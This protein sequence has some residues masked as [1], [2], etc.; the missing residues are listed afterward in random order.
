MEINEMIYAGVNIP[1][2][3]YEGPF[4]INRPAVCNGG[5][6]SF[7]IRDIE[8][9]A[10]NVDSNGV[11]LQNISVFAASADS[12]ALLIRDDTLLEDISVYGTVIGKAAEEGFFNIPYSLSVGAV[13]PDTP[14]EFSIKI[15]IP[16]ECELSCDKGVTLSADRLQAGENTLGI[17]LPGGKA[18]SIIRRSVYI[19]T[20]VTR[21]MV[22]TAAVD[23]NAE[24]KSYAPLLFEP[25]MQSVLS[26]MPTVKMPRTQ[27]QTV[28]AVDNRKK[29]IG[30]G[31]TQLLPK[32][33]STKSG[34]TKLLRGM[35]YPI[36]A[37]DFLEILFIGESSTD[38]DAYV[39]MHD[40]SMVIGD[41]RQL[42]FFGNDLS[43][44]GSVSY[45]HTNIKRAV[46]IDM[47]KISAKTSEIDV[48]YSA[49]DNS[50]ISGKVVI[51]TRTDTLEI[52]I[53]GSQTVTAFE[54]NIKPPAIT[55]TPLI[56]PYRK[57]IAELIRSY[58]LEVT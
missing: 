55:L 6:A 31:I 21:K 37:D 13:Y 19:K 50:E 11:R 24:K 53:N 47:K 58:G 36:S 30:S 26:L 45:L 34:I 38:V 41:S 4:L 7:Y 52:D 9:A 43:L 33:K 42:V 28:T 10:L 8:T 14:F 27:R 39:F 25:E 51:K 15:S 32:P 35:H 5:G 17:R 22:F 29:G 48:V 54:I 2:G 1:V 57:G 49:Y 18:G 16:C 46:Y 56:M 3:E 44:D 12:P 20:G 23:E 40:G